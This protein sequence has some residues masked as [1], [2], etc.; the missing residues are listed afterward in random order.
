MPLLVTHELLADVLE[1]HEPPAGRTWR[2]RLAP[3]LQRRVPLLL[4]CSGLTVALVGGLA[5]LAAQDD[6][7]QA[8]QDATG[9]AVVDASGM[10]VV[11]LD[12]STATG[13]PHSTA[14]WE[15]KD[16]R[17]SGPI[18]LILPDRHLF[19]FAEL[20]VWSLSPQTSS[21]ERISGCPT[22][23][24]R[25]TPRSNGRPATAPSRGA[26]TANHTLPEV[27]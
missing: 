2:G 20:K 14:S 24:G 15:D 1:G 12:S 27:R 23:G 22:R 26:S 21:L 17:L 13:R 11:E 5:F 7:F 3:L 9:A 8:A 25:C 10:M 6:T 19:G 16:P 18:Q 4:V